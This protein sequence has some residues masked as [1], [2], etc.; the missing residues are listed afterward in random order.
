MVGGQLERGRD[1]RLRV[2]QAVSRESHR[3][4]EESPHRMARAGVD[5]LERF[6]D[7]WALP[8]SLRFFLGAPGEAR[9]LTA[10][11]AVAGSAL[12]RGKSPVACGKSSAGMSAPPLMR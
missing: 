7:G 11:A 2:S 3:K 9:T 1:F 6:R 12:P 10:G 8:A 4:T 5:Q